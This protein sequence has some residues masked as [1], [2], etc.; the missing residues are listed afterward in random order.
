MA[1]SVNP[2]LYRGGTTSGS[3]L[4]AAQS[5]MARANQASWA[6]MMS[7]WYRSAPTSMARVGK[8]G[9]GKKAKAPAKLHRHGVSLAAGAARDPFKH[10]G[11]A[12]GF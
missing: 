3:H 11:A 9:R 7:V 6:P 8:G 10:R 12:Q 2:A 1:I 4:S 5:A